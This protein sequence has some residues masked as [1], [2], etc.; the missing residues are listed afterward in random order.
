MLNGRCSG[1]TKCGFM[2]PSGY[3]AIAAEAAALSKN[4]AI[5]V[6]TAIF[7][8]KDKLQQP[9]GVP[10]G[11]RDCY[12]AVVDEEGA[13]FLVATAPRSLRRRAAQADFLAIVDEGLLVAEANRRQLA[14][15]VLS[16]VSRLQRN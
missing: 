5:V 3:D 8:S 16:N 1:P 14:A 10:E 2:S 7:G 4:C 11:L 9:E 12:F 15:S 6:L 13:N